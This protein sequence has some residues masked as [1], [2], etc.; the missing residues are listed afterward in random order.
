MFRVMN[1]PLAKEVKLKK[2]QE[3][4]KSQFVIYYILFILI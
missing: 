3:R 4:Y 2:K 1:G